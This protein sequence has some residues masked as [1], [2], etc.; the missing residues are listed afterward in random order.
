L[1][2]DYTKHPGFSA[3]Y[4]LARARFLEAARD[5]GATIY[6][7]IYPEC[8]GPQGEE[9]AQDLA[10]F[11]DHKAEHW[12]VVL[13]GTH[14]PEGYAGSAIQLDWINRCAAD[15]PPSLG[16]ALLHGVNPWGYAYGQRTSQ[17]G[18]DLNRNFV[19]QAAR[20]QPADPL[21]KQIAA[22][23]VIDTPGAEV[24]AGFHA[25][26]K[27][28]IEKHGIS[29]YADTV[30]RGQYHDRSAV[31]YGGSER[32]WSN[33]TLEKLLTTHLTH[34]RKIGLIDWHTGLGERGELFFICFNTSKEL[35]DRAVEWWGQPVIR[36]AGGF[37]GAA[38]PK[39]TGT[40][41]QGVIGMM[42]K[43]Q[44]VAA[45]I[46]MGTYPFQEM[47]DALLVENWLR[48]PNG[49]NAP[50]RDKWMAWTAERFNPASYDWQESAIRHGGEVM[51]QALAGVVA[52]E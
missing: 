36:D 25:S 33:I 19:D 38:L 29:V 32:E 49:L 27:Q 6:S 35:L 52:W 50:D 28:L 48:S 30:S 44:V 31:M 13:S 3:N 7:E 23:M 22:A 51:A 15:I 10:L 9:L 39:Y 47:A 43:A 11:G 8:G 17:N 12:L 46:E 45:V 37:S 41:C 4:A 5:K 20:I 24:F 18:V 40:V 2:I 14:G 26:T 42:S 16:V 1:S 34:A 21:F